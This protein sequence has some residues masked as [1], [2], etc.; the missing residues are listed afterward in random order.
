MSSGV[1]RAKVI[2][3]VPGV[4]VFAYGV[5]YYDNCTTS[6]GLGSFTINIQ[7]KYGVATVGQTSGPIPGCPPGSPS[8]PLAASWY[9]MNTSSPPAV[10]DYFQLEFFLNGADYGPVD[11]YVL[12]GNIVGKE[13]GGLN[14]PNKK[15]AAEP[16][17][18]A[19]GNVFYSVTDYTTSGQN[20]LTFTRYYNSLGH[21]AT[22][23]PLPEA[24][25]KLSATLATF[26]GMNWRSNFDRYLRLTSDTTVIAERPDGQQLNFTLNGSTW[27]PDTDV[28]MTLSQ[29][30]NQW[31][32]T[33]E[34]D[35]VETYTTATLLSGISVKALYAQLNS[36]RSRNGYTQTL[37]Y[38][39]GTLSSVT[40]SYN[41]SLAFTYSNGL[42]NSVATPDG[43]VITFGYT[44]AA[45]GAG[46]RLTSV[47]YS[48]TPQTG[49]TFVYGSG[50]SPFA[51]TSIVDEDGNTY[52]TWAYDGYARGTRSQL[53]A[54]AYATSVVYNSD[55]SRTVTNAL[56]VT[57]TYKVETLQT[58]PKIVEMDRAATSTTAAASEVFTY[59]GNGYLASETDWNGNQTGFTNNDHGL[60]TT[61]N[62]AVG[63]SAARITTITYDSTWVHL[64]ASIVQS[65]ITATF[66][67][68][69]QG[70]LLTRVLKDT[71]TTTVPYSTSGQTRT[72]TNTWSNSLLASAQTPNGNTSKFSYDST[73][74]LISLTDALNHTTRITSHT[75]GGL[76][77]VTVDPNGVTTTRTYDPRQRITSSTVSGSTGTYQTSWTYDA[78][79]N[80]IRTTLPDNSYLAN[81][82]DAA[83]RLTKINDAEGNYISFTLDALGDRT[84]TSIE[85]S[86]G[87][88]AWR[89]SGAFD[90]LG[91]ELVETGGAGQTTTRTFDPNGNVMTVTDTLGHTTTN[92]YDALNRLSSSTDAIGAVTTLAYDTHDRVVG[93]ADANGNPT[94]YVRDGF[95]DT[96]QQTS[97]DSGMAVFYYDGDANLRSK[98]D[99]LRIVTNQTFDPLDRPLTTTY[100]SNPAENVA[101]SYDQTGSGFSFGVGRLTS[102]TDAGGSL[103]RTYD[104]LGNLLAERRVNGKTSLTTGYTYDAASRIASMTYPDGTLVKYQH[105]PAGYLAN[106]SAR[107]SGTSIITPIGAFTHEPFGPMNAVTYGNGITETWAFDQSYRPTNIT[108][109]LSSVAVQKLTYAYDAANN[110]NSI[111]DAVNAANNQTLG[112]DAINRLVSATSGA[113]G[114][115]SYSWTYDKVGNR[116]TQ[117]AGSTTTA[118]GYTSGANRLATIATS[119]PPRTPATASATL[120][121]IGT[122]IG[123][124]SVD[125][126]ESTFTTTPDHTGV[127]TADD[128]F[129]AP[130]TPTALRRSAS[131]HRV[132]NEPAPSV[133]YAS[134][135]TT[136]PARVQA[137][138]P[139][140]T[141][142]TQPASSTP[143]LQFVP[144]TPC[145][146]V[147]TRNP[148][149]P[150][151]GPELAGG[152]SRTFNIPAGSCSIPPN[153]AAY[154]LN[155]T[156]VPNGAL[157]YLTVWPSGQSQP[158]VSTLNSDGRVKANAAIVPAGSDGGINIYATNSTQAIID[159]DGYF[160][161]GTTSTLAFYPLRPCRIVDTRKAAGPL[162]GPYL[163]G[164]VVRAFPVLSSSCSIPASAQAYSLNFTAVPHGALGYLTVWPTGETQPTVS[165]LNA[166]TG[167]ATANAAIVPAGS[168]GNIS[169]F[170]SNNTDLV[171][172]VN[173]Y[174]APP[175]SGGL[176]LYTLTPCRVLD[177]RK[178]SGGFSGTL[179][180]SVTGSSCGALTSA[181]QAFVLNATVVPASTLGYLTLWPNGD[182]QPEVSTLNAS[183]GAITSNLAIVPAS[184]G[185]IDSF[186]SNQTQLILDISGFFTPASPA[187]TPQFSIP[188]GTYAAAQTVSI[189]D[190]T[191]QATIYYTTDGS[192]P[193]TSSLQY[194]QPIAVSSSETIKAISASIGYATS[195]VAS[196]T[197]AITNTIVGTPTFSPP[198]GT[199]A[200]GQTVA[201][202]DPT[203]GATIYFTT[204]GTTPTTSSTQYASPIILSS[205]VTIKAIAAAPGL[206][207]SAIATAL[208]TISATGTISVLTNANGNITSIPPENAA[209]SATFSYNAANRLSSVTGTALAAYYVYDYAGKRMSKT[210]PSSSPTLYSYAPDGSLISEN[211]NGMLT[212]YIYADGRPVAVLEPGAKPP[213]NQVNYI[214]ADLQGTPQK[215]VNTTG[216]TVWST[217]YTAFGDG[218]APASTITQNLRMPGQHYDF[219]TGFHH[220]GFR[221]Y[222]PNLG[223]YLE[224]D[225]IGLAGGVNPFL[226]VDANP[227]NSFDPLGLYSWYDFK[228]DMSDWE[229]NALQGLAGFTDNL[230]FS[231]SRLARNGLGTDYSDPCALAYRV[232]AGI[233]LLGNLAK[234]AY[235]LVALAPKLSVLSVGKNGLIY[236]GRRGAWSFSEVE[237]WWLDFTDAAGVGVWEVPK[238]LV[239]KLNEG[240][241]D[242]CGCQSH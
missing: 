63:S 165:T 69:T 44:A 189:T 232:G 185:S 123:T 13:L 137:S 40:D 150:F 186:A 84:Q 102:V 162:G 130:T 225:P 64:P 116:L 129:P 108:D 121:S 71:T 132:N 42:L 234:D 70:E 179:T 55:G 229:I 79:G 28:D 95:G 153:A 198:A 41:R 74:A 3:A 208:Y 49:Q 26:T 173:G 89:S 5:W 81:T 228:I 61:V 83:H 127:R 202:Q 239:K 98:T 96:I 174:F 88:L 4:Q 18:V 214:L 152:A 194:T 182:T 29:S 160:A 59:D 94:S 128:T 164:S 56:G 124:S 134:Y 24:D 181:A 215:A 112:Y 14:T 145:R 151:G 136:A 17:D 183:D 149:G 27:A 80:L 167:V 176:S 159:I 144:V 114:Y 119:T 110:V 66:S 72:W 155:V 219:E 118:Y 67:Y 54:G 143:A 171:I 50:A 241:N 233:A 170:A 200:A 77:L 237:D 87:T 115:G 48:T 103:T 193:T 101:Y 192:V 122:V 15:M 205:T 32:L 147:D 141:S 188:G 204:D 106:V 199:Y 62:E 22:Q 93:I 85:T 161:P 16:I 68:D 158:L 131:T 1:A 216:T 73:A 217:T 142:E 30:G 177:T 224:S 236:G 107:P 175:A 220:N 166:P 97:P 209:S 65:G 230:P 20:P 36:I 57:D 58:I 113:G 231:T 187:D 226:Y 109:T 201:L 31:T 195:A 35:T 157:G 169:V 43:L 34:N 60:P 146:V 92:G 210:N 82:Y 140:S 213:A 100:P 221:D 6:A 99:A 203:P 21:L 197:Y 75:P 86:G 45:A 23:V 125:S 207:L 212:D 38:A 53:G 39:S 126:L 180:V 8:L 33:D 242:K 154:S 156:V 138:S 76:P 117:V 235:S 168:S 19:S 10:S 52:A 90:S 46:N 78:A 7:P 37:N 111:T 139:V 190:A 2:S 105:D 178:S 9:T 211:N 191:S 218:G 11:V 222:M 148:D 12:N 172:D 238:D 163:Q 184:N 196:A 206:T 25:L 91:R 51:I 135:V 133:T 240:D 104:E 120:S 227:V 223:R 47:N